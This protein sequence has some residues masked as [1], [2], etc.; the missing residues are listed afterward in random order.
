MIIIDEAGDLVIK[1]VQFDDSIHVPWDGETDSPSC[2]RLPREEAGINKHSKTLGVLLA[3]HL[4]H[5][6]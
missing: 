1:V 6:L 2:A 4:L 3:C 5:L